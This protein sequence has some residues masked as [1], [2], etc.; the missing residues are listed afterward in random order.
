MNNGRQI[1]CTI[2]RPGGVPTFQEAIGDGLE[3]I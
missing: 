2:K 3:D 1:I